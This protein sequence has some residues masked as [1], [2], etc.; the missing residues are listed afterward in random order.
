MLYKDG[1]GFPLTL[2][3]SHLTNPV[4]RM[5]T[6]EVLSMIVK[7]ACLYVPEPPAGSTNVKRSKAPLTEI[8]KVPKEAFSDVE[9]VPNEEPTRV[10]KVFGVAS[11]LVRFKLFELACLKL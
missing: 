10:E 3:P 1:N 5:D 11:D 7:Q 8:E 9:K 4:Q 2:K 6:A